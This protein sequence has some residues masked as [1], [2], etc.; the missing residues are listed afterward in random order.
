MMPSAFEWP[1]MSGTGNGICCRSSAALAN[2]I[3]A[4]SIGPACSART[5]VG[6]SAGMI[7]KYLRSD[8]SPVSGTTPARSLARPLSRRKQLIRSRF[9]IPS[10]VGRSISGQDLVL[11]YRPWRNPYAIR[12]DA[13]ID[14]RAGAHLHIVPQNRARDARG[15]MN[16]GSPAED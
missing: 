5:N 1:R 16:D 8:A 4:N 9:A 6:P 15:W 13:A 11:V 3:V 2:G 12:E 7:R 14:R 10:A